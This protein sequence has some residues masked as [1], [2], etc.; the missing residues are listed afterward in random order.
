[1]TLGGGTWGHN[2]ISHNVTW[3]YLLNFTYVSKPIP[4]YEPKDEDLFPENI[5]KKLDK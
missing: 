4:N 5:R 3:R 1:M 2:S